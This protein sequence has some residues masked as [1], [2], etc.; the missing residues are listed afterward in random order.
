MPPRSHRRPLIGLS[1]VI[2]WA[3]LTVSWA[4]AAPPASP[5]KELGQPLVLPQ[6]RLQE[7]WLSAAR[8]HLDGS[9]FGQAVALLR[10]VLEAEDETYSLLPGRNTVVSN[11]EQAAQLVSRLPDDVRLRL[12]TELDLAAREASLI[13]RQDGSAEAM[14]AFANRYRA[15]HLGLEALRL[16]AANERDGAH[17]AQA[18][19][20]WQA[21]LRHPLLSGSQRASATVALFES[22][23]AAGELPA[24]EQLMR[25]L[26]SQVT[27]A[28]VAG[29]MIDVREWGRRRIDQ[30]KSVSPIG[31]ASELAGSQ[32]PSLRPNWTHSLSS[33]NELQRNI[34]L[35]RRYYR[36]QGVVSSTLL[37]PLVVG[38]L[39][40]TRSMQDLAACDLQTGEQVW[41]VPNQEYGWLT[42]PPGVLDSAVFRSAKASAWLRRTEADSVFAGMATNGKFVVV[43]Q[44]PDRSFNDLSTGQTRAGAAQARGGAVGIN[45]VNNRWNRLCAYDLANRQLVWQIGGPPTGPAD[46]YG[47]LT[48]LSVP[49][50]VDQLMYSVAR[51]DDEMVLLAMDQTTG[52]LR[53]SVNL[54][55][56]APHLA[57][58]FA[59][60]RIACPVTVSDGLLLCPTAAGSLVAVSPV[61]RSIE[62]VFR[63]PLVQHDI[64]LRLSNATPPVVMLPDVWWNEWREMT[65][66]PVH[67]PGQ[68]KTLVLTSP[69]TDQLHAIDA[70]TGVEL[71]HVPRNGGLHLA[72]VTKSAAIVIEPMGVRAHDLQSGRVTWRASTGEI[73]GRGVI[74]GDQFLQPKHDGGM[75]V[76]DLRS[77][78]QSHLLMSADSVCDALTACEGGWIARSDQNLSRLPVLETI[79]RQL[80]ERF[81]LHRDDTAAIELARLDLQAS[82]PIA[83]RKRLV[84]VELTDSKVIRQE[85]LLMLLRDKSLRESVPAADRHSFSRGEL[86]PKLL[87]LAQS[88]DERLVALKAVADAASDEGDVIG[89]F[90]LYLD[91]LAAAETIGSRLLPYWPA[92]GTSTRIVRSDRVLLGAVQRLLDEASRSDTKDSLEKMLN[93][94]LEIARRGDP[95]AAQKLLDRLLPLEWARLAILSNETEASYA[96][97]LQKAEP[98]LLAVAGSANRESSARGLELFANRQAEAGWRADAEVIHRRMLTRMPGALLARG[99]TLAATLASQPDRADTRTRL[100]S[101][102]IDRWPDRMP[103]VDQQ[104]VPHGDVHFVPVRIQSSDASLLSG[105]DV[106]VRRDGGELQFACAGYSGTWT[107]LLPRPPKYLRGNFANLDQVEAHA[108]GHQLI[109]RIGSEVFGVLPFNARGEPRAELTDLRLDMAP[110]YS[111]LPNEL[112]PYPEVAPAKVGL[113][114]EGARLIESSGRPFSGLSAVC[115]NYLCYRSQSKVV[116]ADLQ[117]GRRLWERFDLPQSCLVLGDDDFV[118]LWDPEEKTIQSLSV[119]DGHE[120]N[121]VPWTVSPDDYLMQQGGRVWSIDRQQLTTI[122]LKNARDGSTMW[123]RDF[124]ENAIPF[125]MDQ[126]TLGVVD[127]IGTLHILS[128]DTGAPL[129]EP[130]TVECPDRIERIVS[131]QDEHR[132]YVAI[133]APVPKLTNLLAEQLWGAS[134]V[135]FVNGWL[136]GIERKTPGISWRRHLDSECLPRH[137]SQFAPVIL[138][139]GRRPVSDNPAE[140]NLVGH[141]RILDKRTGHEIL[142][143]QDIALHAY[144]T[145]IPSDDFETLMIYTERQTFRLNY[146]TS[147]T[148]PVSERAKDN[149]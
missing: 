2:G 149:K 105:L 116:V 32:L 9:D 108:V 68:S 140:T 110:D 67:G 74:A 86:G 100:L 126:T 123:S 94:R 127:P 54:G 143:R 77:G 107:K 128:A 132:W 71:W 50:F 82:D 35:V 1:L 131:L 98:I 75:V 13:A 136:Y 59:R 33:V 122:S 142:T 99:E 20:A 83:A 93:E 106:A 41:S 3:C 7:E 90:S 36:D 52:H 38:N 148:D 134:R 10:R 17:H 49:T 102:P 37:R 141:L 42:K 101:P 145:L 139:M 61:T 30:A 28:T 16:V 58:N 51:R 73:S 135:T 70:A 85:A 144:S 11:R 46:Q 130:L 26:P 14:A 119:I 118:Y 147:T 57:D 125:V 15:S 18:L 104:T 25:D 88:D 129:G 31:T 22:L 137:V 87:E 27:T 47:G 48:F 117:T 146:D 66:Q 89:A 80:Q 120:V 39:V 81:D 34:A 29:K 65:C 19:V 78:H 69:D 21:V 72:G 4:W 40:L 84:G 114:H 91:G 55:V 23:L 56:L 111:Q 8:K 138:Q 5:M 103:N 63:Y 112:T 96:R 43:V 44:E 109:L 53:W 115:A 113:R 95:F 97:T 79:R 62:W 92:D 133:S 124:A 45:A 60:H 6:D 12:Q 24:A 76:I 64:P 121:Q